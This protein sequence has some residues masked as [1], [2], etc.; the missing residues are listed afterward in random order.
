M[1][2]LL[3]RGTPLTTNVVNLV[4]E[5]TCRTLARRFPVKIC[6]RPCNFLWD[7]REAAERVCPSITDWDADPRGHRLDVLIACAL[8]MALTETGR[9]LVTV[10][11]V[12][13]GG[14]QVVDVAGV[15]WPVVKLNLP[16]EVKNGMEAF[17]SG[18]LTD[19]GAC[20]AFCK[21]LFVLGLFSCDWRGW[22]AV[23][24]VGGC[25]ALRPEAAMMPVFCGFTQYLV[26]QPRALDGVYARAL[27]NALFSTIGRRNHTSHG[28]H[29][30]A[31]C[32][33]ALSCFVFTG[34]VSLSCVELVGR[35]RGGWAPG[36]A[37]P[38]KYLREIFSAL[39]AI[40]DV[41]L[42]LDEDVIVDDLGAAGS[43]GAQLPPVSSLVDFGSDVLS[44]AK[45]SPDAL[46]RARAR[47]VE[48]LLEQE[49][50]RDRAWRR[51]DPE[52]RGPDGASAHRCT[53]GTL[54]GSAANPCALL[55]A[56]AMANV[57]RAR[58]AAIKAAAAARAATADAAALASGS[59]RKRSD[60]EAS[61]GP[62]LAVS[63]FYVSS[64]CAFRA[65]FGAALRQR[66]R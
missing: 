42:Q 66:V 44:R 13:A 49:M 21:L 51:D 58:A 36:S 40:A 5:L 38:W 28:G 41:A 19:S 63:P 14:V 37:E 11:E 22:A 55:C 18:M 32:G 33:A 54:R 1:R 35:M 61:T 16:Y 30:A 20:A 52:M 24:R 60:K 43:G 39:L 23:R 12:L 29:V 26:P 34:K 3:V 15:G 27:V 48:D 65:A 7:A 53:L 31:A 17:G 59:K 62:S 8:T 45:Q 64:R 4:R 57:A 46:V 2:A 56:A 6:R 9:R 10:L 47:A 25:H 50:P